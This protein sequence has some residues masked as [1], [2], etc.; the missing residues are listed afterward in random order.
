MR[1]FQLRCLLAAPALLLACTAPA[2]NDDATD[3]AATRREVEAALQRYQAAA[4]TVNPDSVAAFYAPA[5]ILFEPGIKPIQTRDS[6]RAFMGSFPGV[7]VDSATATPDTIEVFGGTAYLWGSYFERLSFPGQPQSEQHGKFVMEWVRQPDG[8]WL[9]Q[10]LFRVP[11]PSPPSA[12]PGGG[13]P[14]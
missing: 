8:R 14:P 9:I 12:A 6:I 4:R 7:R 1:P 13:N 3:E 11:I 10:R 5:A 2:A